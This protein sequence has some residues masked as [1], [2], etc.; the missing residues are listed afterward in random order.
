MKL[1]LQLLL[2]ATAAGPTAPADP[3]VAKLAESVQALA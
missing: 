2:V 3:A 1:K